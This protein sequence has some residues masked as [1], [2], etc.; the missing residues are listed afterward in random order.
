MDIGNGL[1]ERRLQRGLTQ[2]ELAA[3]VAVT[4][5]TI[6]AIEKA[7]FTPSVRLALQLAQVLQT[8]V[9]ELFWLEGQVEKR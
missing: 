5:Q 2:E 3:R 9:E 4:R 8:R 6:I 1:K 7:K